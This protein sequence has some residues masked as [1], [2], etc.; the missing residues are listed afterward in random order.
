MFKKN[1]TIEDNVRREG[2]WPI[3]L[4]FNCSLSQPLL[5]SGKNSPKRD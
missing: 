1:R 2:K 5:T 4:D 3:L